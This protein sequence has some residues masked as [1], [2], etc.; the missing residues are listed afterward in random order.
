MLISGPDNCFPYIISFNFCNSLLR[1]RYYYYYI[2]GKTEAV[3]LN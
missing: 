2:D 3:I 1:G